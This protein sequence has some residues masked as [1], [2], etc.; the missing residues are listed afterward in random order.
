MPG[1]IVLVADDDSGVR[2]AM[3]NFLRARGF[4]PRTVSSGEEALSALD[5]VRPDVILLDVSAPGVSGMEICRR[6][7]ERSLTP[8]IVLSE[9]AD[10]RT[11][12]EALNGGADDYIVKPFGLDELEARIRVALRRM[13]APATVGETVFRTGDLVLDAGHR[14]VTLR[15]AEIHLTPTEYEVL[16]YLAA[17]A[18]R[19][20][21]HTML[22][23][24]VWGAQDVTRHVAL[25]N[26][27]LQLRKK[28]G[29]D[30][31]HPRYIVTEPGVG[32]RLRVPALPEMG[33]RSPERDAPRA[34]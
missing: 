7:R 3:Y 30:V 9:I 2:R 34:F 21:T 5:T 18:D 25:R 10:Q 6:I 15:G 20:A 19:L 12:V 11:K 1:P 26:T 31:M 24:A 17:Y 16:K 4:T 27:V 32:Y 23:Q 8:L 28:L 22:L 29:D 33:G 14:R 13:I